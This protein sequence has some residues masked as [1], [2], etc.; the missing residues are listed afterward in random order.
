[1]KKFVKVKCLALGIGALQAFIGFTAIVGGSQLVAH[2]QGTP[3][4]P[5]EMLQGSPFGSFFIPGI[6]LLIFIGAV[7]L[8]SLA[9]TITGRRHRGSVAVIGGGILIG[10]MAAEVWWIGLQNT[11]QPLYLALGAVLVLSGLVLRKM[12]IDMTLNTSMPKA[13]PSHFRKAA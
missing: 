9:V 1:M 2:P 8:L 13:E 10:Y 6:V 5:I 4:I 7:N 11:L 3:A 12:Q